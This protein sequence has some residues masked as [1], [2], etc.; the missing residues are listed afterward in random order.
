VPIEWNEPFGLIII[1]AMLSGCPVVAFQRGSVAELVEEG[2]TG[3]V[4]RD[5]EHMA[6]LVRPGG[7]V[8][9]FNR[10]RCRER[11]VERFS[12]DRMVADHVSLYERIRRSMPIPFSRPNRAAL[13]RASR[14]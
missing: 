10:Q 6:S 2:V 11:A 5:I 13:A 9:S 7:A 8:D 3:F 4:A 1:E 12:R 14:A